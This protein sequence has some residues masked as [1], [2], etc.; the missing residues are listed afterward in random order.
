MN[1][2]FIKKVRSIFFATVSQQIAAARSHQKLRYVCHLVAQKF[3]PLNDLWNAQIKSCHNNNI[4]SLIFFFQKQKI[5]PFSNICQDSKK[6]VCALA[7]I[8]FVLSC[9][10]YVKTWSGS[11]T[12]TRGLQM[13]QP[14]AS[15]FLSNVEDY[16]LSYCGHSHDHFLIGTVQVVGP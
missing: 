3:S 6:K 2:I 12:V 15:I 8:G 1:K 16:P 14:N 5:G 13:D 11:V 7:P 10:M 4:F 9:A